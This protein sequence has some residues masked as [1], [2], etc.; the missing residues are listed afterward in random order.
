MCV[1]G[2]KFDSRI[3]VMW[4]VSKAFVCMCLKHIPKDEDEINDPIKQ[5]FRVKHSQ[6]KIILHKSISRVSKQN[7]VSLLYIIVEIHHSGR[8]PSIFSLP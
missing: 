6:A 7:G 5:S 8:K 4:V 2:C 1:L 3:M